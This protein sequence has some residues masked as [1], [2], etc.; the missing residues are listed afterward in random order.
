MK[1][2]IVR[3]WI[4]HPYD[5][6][7]FNGTAFFINTNM[8]LTAKHVIANASNTIYNDIYLSDTPD[9][10]I[11]PI[12]ETILCKRDIAIL[13]IKNSFNIVDIEFTKELS[14]GIDVEI[15]GFHDK[16]GARNSKKHNVS[17]YLNTTHTYELQNHLSGGLSGSPVFLEGKICGIT[18]AINSKKNITYIIPIEESC[19]QFVKKALKASKHNKVYHCPNLSKTIEYPVGIVPIDSLNYIEREEDKEC[20]QALFDIEEKLIRIKAPIQYGKTSLLTRVMKRAKENDYY[21]VFLEFQKFDK[22]ILVDI[23]E[24][25]EY[26]HILIIDKLNI[27]VQLHPRIVNR[28]P[29]INKATRYME[30]VL[31][32]IDKPLFLIM[33]ETNKLFKY[34]EVSDS[35]FSMIR[36]WHENAKQES[37]WKKLRIILGHSIDPLLSVENINQSPFHNVGLDIKLKAFTKDEIR[38]LSLRHGIDFEDNELDRFM[39]FVGGHPFLSRK[40]LYTIA[41]KRQTLDEIIKNAHNHNTI[42]DDL[43]IFIRLD[44][45]LKDALKKIL[46]GENCIDYISCYKL[47]SLGI[48]RYNLNRPKFSCDL[49]REFFRQIL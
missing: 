22:S 34:S 8:L 23:K 32:E 25:L 10:G 44:K 28:I 17:G 12:D 31:L 49:Y 29:P 15:C 21:V 7:I 36:A 42:F 47:E 16:D 13:K 39:S 48:I 38:D 26:M 45:N 2:I 19:S 41:K 43:K 27:E 35:F 37:L 20:Y 14:I 18:Q 6:G 4:G 33:D 11:V 46:R 9:G 1:N 30:K 40:I 5:G 24:L 3:V